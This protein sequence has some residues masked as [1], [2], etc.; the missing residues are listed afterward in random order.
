[1]NNKQIIT[2]AEYYSALILIDFLMDAQKDSVEGVCLDYLVTLVE[3]YEYT[4][5]PLNETIIEIMNNPPPP[6][7]RLIEDA[8]RYQREVNIEQ[9][10]EEQND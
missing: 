6:N 4:H 2:N 3:Y 5:Y 1:M 7:K 9:H 8:E 10:E